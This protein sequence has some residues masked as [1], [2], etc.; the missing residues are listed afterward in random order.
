MDVVVIIVV[1]VIVSVVVS[2]TSS[3]VAMVMVVAIAMAMAA[4]VEQEG[5]H[6][7]ETELGVRMDP[8]L[9]LT[10]GCLCL[11][12]RRGGEKRGKRDK[13]D[14]GGEERKTKEE[15]KKTE[16][17]IS[18]LS[19]IRLRGVTSMPNKESQEIENP[20]ISYFKHIRHIIHISL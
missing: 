12:K 18:K 14:R 2:S 5:Q 15:N 11:R 9:L 7:Q 6:A 3:S 8:H 13:S 20:L 4:L 19:T 16:S 17:H 10:S 1:F